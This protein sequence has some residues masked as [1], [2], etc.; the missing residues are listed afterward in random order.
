[1]I[2]SEGISIDTGNS[3]PGTSVNK[4]RGV[5][6]NSLNKT[7][8][9]NIQNGGKN[10]HSMK[11]RPKTAINVSAW[12]CSKEYEQIMKIVG[13]N[14]KILVNTFDDLKKQGV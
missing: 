4:T 9:P 11:E 2:E 3:R 12:E 6:V 13:K 7:F 5:N 10:G 8:Y 1:L 14:R